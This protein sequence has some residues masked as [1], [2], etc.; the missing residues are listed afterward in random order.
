MNDLALLYIGAMTPDPA[1]AGSEATSAAGEIFQRNLLSALAET[2]LPPP[3]VLSYV[4]VPSFPR[5]PLFVRGRS[6]EIENGPRC[7]TV[8]HLNLGPLKIVTLGFTTAWQTFRWARRNRK[9]AHR[10][11]LIYN[12]TAP[13][14][15]I[16]LPVCRLLKVRL[17][18]YVGDINV[19]GEVVDNG[20]FRHLE[21]WL[22]KRTLP[23]LDGLLVCNRSIL[24]DFAPTREAVFIEG[25]VPAS[26]IDRFSGPPP[27]HA[28]FNVVFAGSLTELNGID[29][30]LQALEKIE[31]P[32]LRVSIAGRGPREA[33]VREAA[34][35][36]SRIEYLGLV[37]HDR[38]QELYDRAD[39]LLSLRRTGS[40]TE[41]YV[42]PS[43]VVECLATGRPLLTTT[44]GRIA[45]DFG[46][47]V[48]LV[49]ELNPATLAEAIQ[50]VA[51]LPNEARLATGRRAQ[52]FVRRERTWPVHAKRIA[53]YIREVVLGR[54]R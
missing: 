38:I 39:L 44:T 7:R 54:A 45:Q 10:V 6:D 26:F 13:P 40:R 20:P 22:Q 52:Q 15:A 3:E 8:G 17:V 29:V 19:P 30:L 33:A 42:F 50:T 51:D 27:A 48:Y 21:F 46:E 49:P 36:D 37:P 16:L 1:R 9:A 24:E 53:E 2:S 25:G 18:A 12:L 34:A 14:A 43:K 4:P 23:K 5:A 31:D 11:A 41:R 32:D 28:G 35:R 47:F